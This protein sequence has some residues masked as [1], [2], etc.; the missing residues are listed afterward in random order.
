MVITIPYATQLFLNRIPCVRVAVRELY[1]LII[2]LAWQSH[3]LGTLRNRVDCMSS[4]L[5]SGPALKHLY[6]RQTWLPTTTIRI[7]ACCAL[8]ISA[9]SWFEPAHVDL[10]SR[11]IWSVREKEIVNYVVLT[12]SVPGREVRNKKRH[13]TVSYFCVSST[14]MA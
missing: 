14:C 11:S 13:F 7:C 5:I 8:S 12:S 3:K 10:S 9:S 2:T 1:V 4:L 6:F